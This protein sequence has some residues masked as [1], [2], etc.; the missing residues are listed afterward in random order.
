ME[1]VKTIA[2]ALVVAGAM[3]WTGTRIYA[4]GMANVRQWL[5]W[6]T[7]KAEQELGAGTGKLKLRQVYDMFVTRFSWLARFVS[8]EKFAKIVDKA[9]E[10]MNEMIQTNAAAKK[11]V[12][13][14]EEK[15][16]DESK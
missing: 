5:I 10:E 8:F 12:T 6:A 1:I 9:L 2:I 7:A 16:N 4:G 15:T 3:L 14:E 13:G 11:L